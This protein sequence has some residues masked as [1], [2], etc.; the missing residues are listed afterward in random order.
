MSCTGQSPATDDW[1]NQVCNLDPTS[2]PILCS[3]Q[4]VN[5]PPFDPDR[6]PACIALRSPVTNEAR[7]NILFALPLCLT[8]CSGVASI[9][10]RDIVLLIFVLV[11]CRPPHATSKVNFP[12]ARQPSVPFVSICPEI[13]DGQWFQFFLIQ[14]YEG[15]IQI[16]AM[17]RV[18]LSTHA[19]TP[20][21]FSHDIGPS[22]WM[23]LMVS[24]KFNC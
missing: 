9:V 11:V 6:T 14:N 21:V 20:A 16:S 10:K 17:L 24:F 23:S 5:T 12:S 2:C 22:A 3:C 18:H 4:E 8:Y 19:P 15:I 13:G 7:H 1:C